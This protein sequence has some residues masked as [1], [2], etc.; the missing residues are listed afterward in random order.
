MRTFFVG[1]VRQASPEEGRDTA[2]PHPPLNA[3]CLGKVGLGGMNEAVHEGILTDAT[4]AVTLPVLARHG[5]AGICTP[6]YCRRSKVAPNSVAAFSM[7]GRSGQPQG[8]PF[9]QAVV[10]T[11]FVRPPDICT[12]AVGFNSNCRRPAS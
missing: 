6:Q 8:W 11:P 10:Q 5:S 7:V 9:L 4:P 3:I 1:P 2:S 12:P